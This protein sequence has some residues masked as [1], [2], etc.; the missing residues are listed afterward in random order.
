M[1]KLGANYSPYIKD[2]QVW[3][4]VAAQFLHINF[5]H[6]FGNSLTLLI[7]VSRLEYTFGWWKTLIIYIIS[8]IGGNIFSCLTNP[9]ASVIKAGASTCLFGIIG[10]IIGYIILN[11]RG[12]SIIGRLLKCQLI[13]ISIII[14]LF[15]FVLTPYGN[16]IDYLGHLGGFLTGVTI[17]SI[18]ATILNETR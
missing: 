3:R 16:N 14:I 7:F 6:L 13:F 1:L 2:G 10:A 5:L 12:F 11:W 17:C 15:I 8:G 18:H 4:L 9:S